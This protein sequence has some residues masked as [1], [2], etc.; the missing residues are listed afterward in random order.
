M[1]P[2]L[3]TASFSN[4]ACQVVPWLLVLNTPPV[5]VAT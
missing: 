4:T 1:A 3:A 5:A 2:V